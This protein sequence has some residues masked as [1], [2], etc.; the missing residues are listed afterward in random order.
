MPILKIVTNKEVKDKKD[1]I[2]KASKLTSSLLSK[3]ESYVMTL[4]APTANMSYGGSFD[5]CAF[6]TLKSI[7]LPKSQAANLSK[8][9]CGFIKTELGIKE[10]RIFIEFGNIDGS[11]WGWNSTTF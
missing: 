8:E 10:D 11:L 2:S 6:L 5:D 3:P 7:N 4:L 1:L 9:L